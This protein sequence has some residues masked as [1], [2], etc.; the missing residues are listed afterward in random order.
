MLAD[1]N[2]HK[3]TV[4]FVFVTL[5][6]GM[7]VVATIYK[8]ETSVAIITGFLSVIAVTFAAFLTFV[9]FSEIAQQ[10]DDVAAAYEANRISLDVFLLT[11][12]NLETTVTQKALEDL[13]EIVKKVDKITETAPRVPDRIWKSTTKDKIS[14]KRA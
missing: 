14:I 3:H 7:A 8:S 12:V 2:R 6:V 9:R 5:I 13:K 4:L 1:K 10:H 11:N